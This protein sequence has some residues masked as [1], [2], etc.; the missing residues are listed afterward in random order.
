MNIGA[1]KGSVVSLPYST[2]IA[3]ICVGSSTTY[4]YGY[5]L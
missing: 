5:V 4:Q 3:D 1:L 2:E